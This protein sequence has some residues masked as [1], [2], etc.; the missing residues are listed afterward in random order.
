[1]VEGQPVGLAAAPVAPPPG[2]VGNSLSEG[3][4]PGSVTFDRTKGE[5]TLRGSGRDFWN[6]ADGGYFLN[7]P[8]TG[9]FQVTVEALTLPT[10]TD[11]YAKAG[12]MI[13]ESLDPEA[14]NVYLVTSPA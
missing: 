3:L 6:A 13:R 5:F 9:D 11:P 2:F 7:Q 14:R 1:V 8:V 4:K 10:A 12:L